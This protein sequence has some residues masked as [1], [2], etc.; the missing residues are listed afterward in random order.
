MVLASTSVHMVE[1][2]LGNGCHQCL[3]PQGEFQ[4]PP[5]SPGGSPSG[6]HAGSFQI[7]SSALDLKPGGVLCGLFKSEV[8]LL[9]EL[10]T[11]SDMQMLLL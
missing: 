2:A 9:G 5:V 8:S 6:S 4:L 3:C 7:T 11:T 1:R 10:S